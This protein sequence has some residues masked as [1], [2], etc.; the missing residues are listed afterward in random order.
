MTHN[1]VS[2]PV[3]MNNVRP[4]S[5]LGFL[6][7]VMERILHEQLYDNVETRVFLDPFHTGYRK[8]HSI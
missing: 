1:K 2:N 6:S 4:I 3:T 7:K 5:L 8:G